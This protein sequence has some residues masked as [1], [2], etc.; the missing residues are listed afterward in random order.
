MW[1]FCATVEKST[2]TYDNFFT[3]DLLPFNYAIM[4]LCGYTVNWIVVN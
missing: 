3:F 1:I 2:W 4:C